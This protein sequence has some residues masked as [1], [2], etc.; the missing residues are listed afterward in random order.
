MQYS[1]TREIGSKGKYYSLNFG[2]KSAC[3]VF[4]EFFYQKLFSKS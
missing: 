3:F 2:E 1:H 4:L